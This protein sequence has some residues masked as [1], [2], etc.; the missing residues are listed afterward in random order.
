MDKRIG[1]ICQAL[2]FIERNLPDEIGVEDMA[3]ASGYSLYHFIRLFNQIVHHTPYDYLIRRRLCEAASLVLS[4]ERKLIDIAMDFR[5]Q[6]AETFTRAFSR[7]YHVLPSHVRK[8][9]KLDQRLMLRSRTAAHLYHFQLQQSL[10]PQIIQMQERMIA[11]FTSQENLKFTTTAEL[12]ENLK[13]YYPNIDRWNWLMVFP[14]QD[15]GPD[16]R[17][18]VGC[19]IIDYAELALQLSAKRLPAGRAAIFRYQGSPENLNLTR[20]FIYQTWAANTVENL[21][22]SYEVCQFS[23][24][25][26]GQFCEIEIPLK[27][28]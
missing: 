8:T 27:S 3:A 23:F 16:I 11:G 22:L 10:R 9:G 1:N 25:E 12:A 21:D 5:F 26:Q 20:D 19:E 15:R 6:N 4:T 2:G 17:Q 28:K 13:S 18:M 7:V 14:D 24:Q